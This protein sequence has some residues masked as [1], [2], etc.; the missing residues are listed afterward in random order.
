MNVRRHV[1]INIHRIPI[2]HRHFTHYFTT[3]SGIEIEARTAEKIREFTSSEHHCSLGSPANVI[4][5][6]LRVCMNA[7]TFQICSM[8][9]R[10][11][12]TTFNN[13][14]I[15]CRCNRQHC[16]SHPN[17]FSG[18]IRNGTENHPFRLYADEKCPMLSN[19]LLLVCLFAGLSQSRNMHMSI[20]FPAPDYLAK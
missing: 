5:A 8:Q 4:Y 10:A 15:E 3:Q 1:T 14:A 12:T 16:I 19:T 6:T 13:N 18:G 9:I 7:R 20:D 17:S 2:Q 11:T